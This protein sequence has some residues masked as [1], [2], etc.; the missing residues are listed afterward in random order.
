MGL[1]PAA[2]PLALPAELSRV[3]ALLDDTAFFAPFAPYFDARIGRP[4]IPMETYLQLPLKF[5]Y[6]LGY[7]S[8]C[9]EVADLDL[10]AAVLPHPAGYPGAAHDVD[11]FGREN[12]AKHGMV[13]ADQ[14]FETASQ[15]AVQ[16][17]DWLIVDGESIIDRPGIRV[18]IKYLVEFRATAAMC[19]AICRRALPHMAGDMDAPRL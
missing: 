7:E 8:L 9:R 16:F 14:R 15:A 4:S 11:E 19:G 6:R 3:D 1:D 10:L 2:E 5:R 13:P 17:D 12:R 18:L